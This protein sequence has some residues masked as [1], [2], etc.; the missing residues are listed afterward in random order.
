MHATKKS[1]HRLKVSSAVF[2][3]GVVNPLSSVRLE[4][5]SRIYSYKRIS[6]AFLLKYLKGYNICLLEGD[7]LK[8]TL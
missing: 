4:L 7:I 2:I 5:S 6:H 3:M 1:I 8:L